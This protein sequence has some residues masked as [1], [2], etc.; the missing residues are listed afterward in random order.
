MGVRS[1]SLS[2]AYPLPHRKVTAGIYGALP[3]V[4]HGASL[5]LLAI[6]CSCDRVSGFLWTSS[7]DVGRARRVREY[8]RLLPGLSAGCRGQTG[9][10]EME[11]P[12]SMQGTGV[13]VLQFAIAPSGC[14]F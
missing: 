6:D 7:H 10:E 8:W 12:A 13:D 1:T 4:R 3:G 11:E 14:L 2:P 5:A 9:R